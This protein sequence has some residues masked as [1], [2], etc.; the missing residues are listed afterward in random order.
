M[1]TIL[2]IQIIVIMI[3]RI[4]TSICNFLQWTKTVYKLY[5]LD[6]NSQ[7]ELDEYKIT[8][9]KIISTYDQVIQNSFKN[10]NPNI[11]LE[12]IKLIYIGENGVSYN[13]DANIYDINSNQHITHVIITKFITETIVNYLKT[14]TFDNLS[15][16][17]MVTT[18]EIP[19]FESIILDCPQLNKLIIN[20]DNNYY[21]RRGKEFFDVLKLNTSITILHLQFV[22]G[23]FN[24]DTDQLCMDYINNCTHEKVIFDI[25]NGLK[26]DLLDLSNNKH[27][28]KLIFN[29]IVV[30]Q[31]DTLLKIFENNDALEKIKFLIPNYCAKRSEYDVFLQY[32]NRKLFS[33]LIFFSDAGEGVAGCDYNFRKCILSSIVYNKSLKK[34]SLNF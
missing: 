18:D 34:L 7:K 14:I 33:S 31:L 22:H 3:K 28:K 17:L 6:N 29:C 25:Q 9:Q 11:D 27:L 5:H 23:G 19:L 10:A 30:F 8:H 1:N 15:L 24:N 21:F 4:Y 12:C 20:I 26:I 16:W 32:Q 2:L 13:T